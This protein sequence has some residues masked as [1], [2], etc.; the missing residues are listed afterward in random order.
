MRA[1]TAMWDRIGRERYGVSDDK[2]RRFRYGVQVNS[3]GH[4]SPTREQRAAHRARGP[5]RHAVE[6]R[7]CSIAAAPRLERS[8]RIAPTL[9]STVVAAHPAG[10]GLRDR[11][12]GVRRR[13]RGLEGGRGEDRGAR[14]GGN[15][16]ARR[17]AG[18]RRCVRSHRRAQGPL[19]AK[20]HRTHAPHRERRAQDR[21]RELLHRDGTIPRSTTT[22]SSSSRSI[23]ACRTSSS[24][25]CRPGARIE[26]RTP[27]RSRST[28]CDGSPPRART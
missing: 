24:P 2:A 5:W 28:S 12:V 13:V 27:S 10:A 20:P 18:A 25:T 6:R 9:G 23:P 14:R 3:L 1:F 17:R 21:R 7:P 26:T 15:G 8:A 11:P 22:K 19:G 4:R 16:G